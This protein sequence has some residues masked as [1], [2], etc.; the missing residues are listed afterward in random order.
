MNVDNKKS[1]KNPNF[2]NFKGYEVVEILSQNYQGGRFTYKARE[3]SSK[4]TVIIKQFRFAVAGSDWSGYKALEKEIEFLQTL[5]YPGIPKYQTSF[6]SEDGFCFTLEYIDAKPLSTQ[7]RYSSKEIF[8]L[9]T[10]ILDILVYLQ[11]QEPPVIHRDI[12]PENILIST[13]RQIYLVD[14]GLARLDNQTMST[15]SVVGGTL[16]FMPPEQLLGKKLDTSSDL[17]SLGITLICLLTGTPSTKINEL[18]DTSFEVNYRRLLETEVEKPFLKWLDKMVS[19]TA[20]KRFRS[21][22]MAL[23]ALRTRGSAL[24]ATKHSVAPSALK[25]FG[26]VALFGTLCIL[27]A[28]GITRLN[29][30]GN[31]SNLPTWPPISQPP[32]TTEKLPNFPTIFLPVTKS[33]LIGIISSAEVGSLGTR[34]VDLFFFLFDVM[35]LALGISCLWIQFVNRDYGFEIQY[36]IPFCYILTVSISTNFMAFIL[37]F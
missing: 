11:S 1:G 25:R 31:L 16:G 33:I 22:S 36:F 2:P 29:N 12:K 5:K 6:D 8:D 20:Q 10:K 34:I 3:K 19:P 21:A 26:G 30:S 35:A 18:I 9:A 17:Y 32:V 24:T 4:E 7:K 28:V 15:S 23:D 27:V 13:E 14:F 37:F